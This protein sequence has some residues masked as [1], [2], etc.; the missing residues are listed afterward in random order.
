MYASDEVP[1]VVPKEAALELARDGWLVRF[2]SG[3]RSAEEV[4]ELARPEP[5][6]DTEKNRIRG[7][8][9]MSLLILFFNPSDLLTPDP[10]FDAFKDRLIVPPVVQT[11]V[12]SKIKLTVRDW[13]D[14]MLKWPVKQVIPAP[15]VI[16][17]VQF[18]QN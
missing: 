12:Y 7:W 9:R 4:R 5:A 8:R 13:V 14:K 11:L 10:S 6:E 17:K 18:A 16:S 1:E 2:V 3:G 15:L